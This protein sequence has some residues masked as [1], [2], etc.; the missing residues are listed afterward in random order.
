M[1]GRSPLSDSSLMHAGPHSLGC[2][3]SILFKARS[4]REAEVKD[5][6]TSRLLRVAYSCL[7]EDSLVLLRTAK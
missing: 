3:G 6:V 1:K 7:T 4:V 2:K 5:G